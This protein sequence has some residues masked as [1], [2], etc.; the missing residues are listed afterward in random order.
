MK[1]IFAVLLA[2]AV[3]AAVFAG[4]GNDSGNSSSGS[5]SMP[6]QYAPV[7]KEEKV[8]VFDGGATGEKITTIFTIVDEEG[9]AMYE[10]SAVAENAEAPTVRDLTQAVVEYGDTIPYETDDS[11][12]FISF[13][14]LQ[15]DDT[16]VWSLLYNGSVVTDATN[17]IQVKDGDVIMWKLLPVEFRENATSVQ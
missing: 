17:T 10:G 16:Y 15:S 8:A 2:G 11:G 9:V 5:S 14:N 1:K 7:E 13:G 3:M 6:E 12:E 4:C